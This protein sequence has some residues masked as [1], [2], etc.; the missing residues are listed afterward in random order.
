MELVKAS[1]G[2]SVS[3]PTPKFIRRCGISLPP[4]LRL[5]LGWRPTSS[6]SLINGAGFKVQVITGWWLFVSDQH[7]AQ[8]KI[9]LLSERQR[10]WTNISS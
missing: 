2:I 5:I 6:L 7:S 3:G 9:A 8:K 1:K 10:M 4:W